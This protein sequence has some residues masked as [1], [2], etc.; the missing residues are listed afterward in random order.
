[1]R[2]RFSVLYPS[3]FAIKY[4]LSMNNNKD[5][6]EKEWYEKKVSVETI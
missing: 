1:M 4:F 3:G 5:Y 2:I 6:S